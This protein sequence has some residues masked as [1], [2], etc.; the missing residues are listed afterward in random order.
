MRGVKV[1]RQHGCQASLPAYHCAHVP[2][3]EVRTVIIHREDEGLTSDR[4][5]FSLLLVLLLL[6][7]LLV[8]NLLVLFS[9]V[10]SLAR[11]AVV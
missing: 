9:F 7:S 6:F 10:C 8:H 1:T 11:H 3:A 4:V 5:I 2:R